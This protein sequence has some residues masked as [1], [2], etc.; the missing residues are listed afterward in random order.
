M[1]SSVRP[2][3]GEEERTEVGRRVRECP[4]RSETERTEGTGRASHRLQAFLLGDIQGRGG[5]DKVGVDEEE[6]GVRRREASGRRNRVTP[7]SRGTHSRVRSAPR[8]DLRLLLAG[9]FRNTDPA[10][11]LLVDGSRTQRTRWRLTVIPARIP[12]P[13]RCVQRRPFTLAR[14]PRAHALCFFD[15]LGARW[16]RPRDPGPAS[17][18]GVRAESGPTIRSRPLVPREPPCAGA[19]VVAGPLARSGR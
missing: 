14:A 9:P 16:D 4:S 8:R 13:R 18:Q 10:A 11:P 6:A 3:P 15:R 17:R 5:I 2:R 1:G 12:H 19:R 7:T